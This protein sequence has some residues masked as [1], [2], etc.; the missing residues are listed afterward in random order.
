MTKQQCRRLVFD[1]AEQCEISHP[2]NTETRMAGED[3]LANFIT[4]FKFSIQKPE[5]TSIDRAMDFNKPSVDKFFLILKDLW[6]KHKF[7]T[8]V[9]Y[10]AGESGLSTVPISY[11]RSFHPQEL[12]EFPKSYQ[13]REAFRCLSFVALT[14][15]AITCLLF[16]FLQENGCNLNLWKEPHQEPL[17]IVVIMGGA[18]DIYLCYF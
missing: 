17:A 3:W 9:I 18:M 2:F 6:E 12:R 7:P 15:L 8:S 5:A 11:Q 4:K 13:Q 16:W 1:F 14:L 10:N